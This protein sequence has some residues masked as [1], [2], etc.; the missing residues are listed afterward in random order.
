[1]F[2]V[3]HIEYG[4]FSLINEPQ[5]WIS[6]FSQQQL[7]EGQVQFVQD[8]SRVNTQVIKPQVEAFELTER[9]FTSQYFFYAG[10]CSF[11]DTGRRR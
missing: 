9:Q 6:S 4:H 8:G 1:M 3:S 5:I 7:L 2:Y 11:A 10:K